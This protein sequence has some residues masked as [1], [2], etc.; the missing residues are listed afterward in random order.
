[1]RLEVS[2]NQEEVVFGISGI[3]K[4]S[5]GMALADQIHHYAQIRPKKLTLDFTN[6]ASISPDSVPLV[7]SALEQSGVGKYNTHALGCNPIVGR[8]LQE[9]EFERVGMIG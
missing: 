9:N 6:L 5:D 4:K 7:V 2:T 1:M 3:M 8:T